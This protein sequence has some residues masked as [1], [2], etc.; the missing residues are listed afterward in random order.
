MSDMNT[1]KRR[2]LNAVDVTLVVLGL[3]L[4]LGVA[5]RVLLNRQYSHN[6][7]QRTILFTWI[8][9]TNDAQALTQGSE[10][11]LSSGEKLGSIAQIDSAISV[12]ETL[13]QD[14]VKRTAVTGQ[15]IVKGYVDKNGV[16]CSMDGTA[17]RINDRLALQ[18]EKD[19]WFYID[20]IVE[21]GQ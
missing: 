7:E 20:N 1:T 5:A 16:F 6:I 12:H 15:L 19:C 11:R 2:G 3:L 21:N 14:L 13:A 4:I 17:L 18:N 8:L 10:V 9:P